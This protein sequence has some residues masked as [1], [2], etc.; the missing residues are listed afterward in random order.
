MNEAIQEHGIQRNSYAE[1]QSKSFVALM[2]RA[3]F[4]KT[5]LSSSS[6]D[7]DQYDKLMTSLKPV[8]AKLFKDFK[9]QLK[10]SIQ[11]LNNKF[12]DARKDERLIEIVKLVDKLTAHSTKDEIDRI[13]ELIKEL[14]EEIDGNAD[15]ADRTGRGR[16]YTNDK[17]DLDKAAADK[18]AA[19]KAAADKAASDKAASDKAAADKAAADKAAADKAALAYTALAS[20]ASATRKSVYPKR[21]DVIPEVTISPTGYDAMQKNQRVKF[22]SDIKKMVRNELLAQRSIN[23]VNPVS[24]QNDSIEN[25]ST[26]TD[27]GNEY[28][29]NSKSDMIR[30]DSIPCWGCSLDY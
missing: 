9:T 13:S 28:E 21:Y 11:A 8:D 6:D 19:D 24:N 27:Q 23:H 5:C 18:A 30:K 26:C 12:I 29:H 2:L 15:E 14:N 1:L 17:K 7:C 10:A 3:F 16:I 22:L 4:A 20:A 25:T